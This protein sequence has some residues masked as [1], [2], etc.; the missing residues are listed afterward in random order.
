MLLG[1]SSVCASAQYP[2]FEAH[3]QVDIKH[4]LIPKVSVRHDVKYHQQGQGQAYYQATMQADMQVASWL[5]YGRF[6]LEGTQP[7]S[8][9]FRMRSR[10]L[11]SKKDRAL[12]AAAFITPI[13]DVDTHLQPAAQDL[14]YMDRQSALLWLGQHLADKPL[15]YQAHLS[16]LDSKARLKPLVYQKYADY[17]HLDD[18]ASLQILADPRLIPILEFG[19]WFAD[20]PEQKVLMWMS[21]AYPGLILKAQAYD[22]QEEVVSIRLARWHVRTTN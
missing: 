19:F 16:L 10:L 17:H 3:Y 13:T 1:L 4:P 9:K 7:V 14:P 18:L 2:E 12:D 20:K 8:Q 11:T 22:Q 5:E 6:I 15:G 21:A